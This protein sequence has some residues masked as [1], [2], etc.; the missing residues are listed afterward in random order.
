MRFLSCGR[1]FSSS[2]SGNDR[3]APW[4]PLPADEISF[5]LASTEP[6]PRKHTAVIAIAILSLSN[7]LDKEEETAELL[8]E[9]MT[10][11]DNLR[12][13]GAPRRLLTRSYAH[14]LAVTD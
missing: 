11:S 14:V 3:N 1:L 5:A 6:L 9:Y 8:T 12:G 2:S 13:H 10:S 4:R 7:G